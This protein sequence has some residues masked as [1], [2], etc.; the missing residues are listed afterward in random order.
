MLIKGF[1]NLVS[2]ATCISAPQFESCWGY[3]AK[4]ANGQDSPKTLP[5]WFSAKLNQARIWVSDFLITDNKS[6]RTETKETV[7]VLSLAHFGNTTKCCNWD[8]EQ[9]W[10][11]YSL[12]HFLRYE[13]GKR[14]K[15]GGTRI[16]SSSTWTWSKKLYLM[17]AACQSLRLW[18]PT[19]W[20][21]KE[22]TGGAVMFFCGWRNLSGVWPKNILRKQ[23]DGYGTNTVSQ[24]GKILEERRGEEDVIHWSNWHFPRYC[25][26]FVQLR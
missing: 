20:R 13:I 17:W 14:P 7:S 1:S 24:M 5:S 21:R 12:R 8:N 25:A 22:G 26:V 6:K 10:L 18:I 4:S 16:K 23:I 9:A 11:W 19:F 3:P 2:G 15:S